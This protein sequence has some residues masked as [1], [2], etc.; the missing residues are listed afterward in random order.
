M[1]AAIVLAAGASRRMGRPKLTLPWGGTSVIGQVVSVLQN[2]GLEHI[3]V[4]TGAGRE[5]VEQAL[6]GY[7]VRFAYNSGYAQSEML[8]SIQA[9]LRAMPP[10]AQ[11][12]LITLGDQPQIRPATVAALL[13]AFA[14]HP[15]PL[16]LP[17][18]HGRRGHP[19]LIRRDLWPDLLALRP[20][21]T[22]RD[23]LRAHADS[24]LHLEW[25]EDSILR[26]LDTPED[27]ERE[28]PAGATPCDPDCYEV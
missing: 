9:G 5:Q 8:G 16:I 17:S 23:F 6:A 26:D 3:T 25:A 11:A 19:W 27:Y 10:E 20:P 13:D 7:P 28:R 15:A 4:V 22:P 12:A 18:H 21:A 1:I 2:A 24:I 14:S